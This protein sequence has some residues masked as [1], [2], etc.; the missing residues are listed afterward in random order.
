MQKKLRLSISNLQY[1]KKTAT[2]LQLS[3]SIGRKLRV[4]ICYLAVVQENCNLAKLSS[5]STKKDCNLAKPSCSS[6]K[7]DCNLVKLSCSSA[8]RLQLT[9]AIL[10][11]HK[12]NCHLAKLSCSSAKNST[13][14]LS[15]F[16][17]AQKAATYLSYLVVAQK[18][19]SL[20]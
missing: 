6:T 14:Q 20:S 17:V 1:W 4:S 13:I 15:Y 7:K 8:K 3:C 18:K 10:Q 19:L 16:A 12:K 11:Q 9:Y 5:S 2:L